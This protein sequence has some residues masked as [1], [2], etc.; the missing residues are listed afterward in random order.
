MEHIFKEFVH[1]SKQFRLALVDNSDLS[2][3]PNQSHCIFKSNLYF[4]NTL[5]IMT[6]GFEEKEVKRRQIRKL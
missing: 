1:K 5:T 2:K 3:V 4:I 6:D